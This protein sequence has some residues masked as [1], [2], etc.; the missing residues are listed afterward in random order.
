M[1]KLALLVLLILPLT[2]AQGDGYPPTQGDGYQ[3][4]QSSTL[5]LD[6]RVAI[7]E[8]R[9]DRVEGTLYDLRL[10]P[11]QLSRIEEQ[12]RQIGDRSNGNADILLKIFMGVGGLFIGGLGALLWKSSRGE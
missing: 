2:L 4:G 11:S 12:V 9:V 6:T 1:R 8:N 7:L 10:V 3:P 5:Q